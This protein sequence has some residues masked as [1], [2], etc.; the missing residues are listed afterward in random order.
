VAIPVTRTFTINVWGSSSKL[1]H[2]EHCSKD[3]LYVVK[4]RGQGDGSCVIFL[5]EDGALQRASQLANANLQR[6]LNA[7]VEVVPCPGCGWIQTDMQAVARS[8][9]LPRLKIAG[10]L[11]VIG[12][13]IPLLVLLA[14][15]S[16]PAND[17]RRIPLMVEITIATGLQLLAAVI[18]L[19][20]RSIACASY[21]PNSEDI[22][23]RLAKGLER[24]V[25]LADRTS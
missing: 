7:A 15:W 22:E 6:S 8:Q 23:V 12:L 11:L 19:M 14:T 10:W 18:C 1:V 25:M 4:R 3:Y 5:D 21:D 17:P 9:H 2:C 24:G 13:V 20:G 16:R